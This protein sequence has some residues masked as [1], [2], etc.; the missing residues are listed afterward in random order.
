MEKSRLLCHS[1]HLREA[2]RRARHSSFFIFISLFMKSITVVLLFFILPAHAQPSDNIELQKMYDEDQRS[3][4]THRID[5]RELTKQDSLREMK[6]NEFIRDGRIVTA[7]D[8]YNSAMIFQ[9]GR[10]TVASS[11]AVKHMR[12]AIELDSTMNRWLLAATIDRD[13][14]RRNRPQI[15]GTQYVKEGEETKWKRY[16]IDSATVTDEERKYYGVETLAQQKVKEYELNLRSLSDYYASS[17]SIDKTVDLIRAEFKKKRNAEYNVSEVG[18]LIFGDELIA[19]KKNDE[20]LKIYK[21]NTELYPDLY[22]P[23]YYLGECLLKLD[24]KE[25]ARKAFRKSLELNPKNDRARDKLKEL[26]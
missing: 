11:M 20:A 9:H 10:D 18:L 6:V 13:L 12:K 7:K 1:S 24:R 25:D 22:R 3:R 26:G 16:R 19:A 4:T 5:W 2:L 15:Y 23:Y 14:M 8:Y 21:L 17:K